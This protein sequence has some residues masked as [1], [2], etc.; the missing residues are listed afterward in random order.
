MNKKQIFLT[1]S[2]A[3]IL[4]FST[5][6]SFLYLSQ[7]LN[8]L[9]SRIVNLVNNSAN[10]S[11]TAVVESPTEKT[12]SDYCGDVCKSVIN[13]IVSSAIATI[14]SSERVVEKTVTTKPVGTIYIP[15][16]SSYT[17]TSTDWYT[18]DDTEVYIDLENDYGSGARVS[19]E[20][21]LKV[22]HANGQAFARL[23]DDTNKIAVNGSELTTVNN[24]DYQFVSTGTIPFWKGR[25]LY[26]VQIKSLNSFEVSITGGKIRVTY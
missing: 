7:R 23:W 25:N 18:L 4:L 14:S 15:M 13:D 17:T 8:N 24:S 12:T 10:I 11:E 26:K 22:A 5:V 6:L 20:A 21:L 16:G 2:V 9:E 1:S 19:W 3:I